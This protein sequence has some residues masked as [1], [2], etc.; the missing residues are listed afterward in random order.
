MGPVDG[1]VALGLAPQLEESFSEPRPPGELPRVDL[2]QALKLFT[3]IVILPGCEQDARQ[4]GPRG[5]EPWVDLEGVA[6]VLR[7]QIG[8]P[9]TFGEDPETV[10]RLRQIGVD[11]PRPFELEASAR[12]VAPLHLEEP[13]VGQRLDELRV[14]LE[15]QGEPRL[16][17]LEVALGHRL[18]PRVVQLYGLFRERRRPRATSRERNHEGGQD[19][20]ETPGLPRGVG[21][22]S[23][24][25][26]PPRSARPR[27]S[28]AFV[29]IGD[30]FG[31]KDD[32]PCEPTARIASRAR[33][34]AG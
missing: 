18:G 10:M 16:G 1:G 20:R 14:I 19:Q 4:V 32:P 29:S 30:H 5:S 23:V 13:Q 2:D 15:R 8:S 17:G 6:V 24:E 21:G 31:L 26:A 9:L 22:A 12:E 28:F 3:S 7:C 27:A 25:H 34:S 33:S 11:A